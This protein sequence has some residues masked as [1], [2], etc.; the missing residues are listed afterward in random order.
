MM[1]NSLLPVYIEQ[2]HQSEPP[3]LS[4]SVVSHGTL[5]RA[6]NDPELRLLTSAHFSRSKPP[7]LALFTAFLPQLIK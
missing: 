6:R 5:T 3:A 7:A 1:H 4:Y 2:M